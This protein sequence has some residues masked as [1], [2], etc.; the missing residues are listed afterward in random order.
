MGD[1]D[2]G[3]QFGTGIGEDEVARLEIQGR[4]LAPATRMI[5]AEAGI[6]PGMRVL[7]LGCGAGDVTFV[8]ADLVGP[9]GSVVGVDRSTEALAQARLRAERRGLAQ[10]Q[11][12][13][14]DINDPAPGGP[15][16]AIVERLV[17]WAVP[18]PAALLRRQATVL[19]TGGLVV[20]IET[21]PLLVCFLPGTADPVRAGCESRIGEAGA[22][23]RRPARNALVA[24]PPK[25]G[26]GSQRN[27]P[28]VP[29]VCRGSLADLWPVASGAA[30]HAPG[31]PPRQS[32][33][34]TPGQR[35]QRA[36]LDSL[37][38]LNSAVHRQ[39]SRFVN[40]RPGRTRRSA[41]LHR[42]RRWPIPANGFGTYSPYASAE[43]VPDRTR[44][45]QDHNRGH[46]L[47]DGVDGRRLG[48]SR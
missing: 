46:L 39:G 17:L 22:R 14:G 16:D 45:I 8:A 42:R 43:S 10:V 1:S 13:E 21:D 2:S 31:G 11:F 5:F 29:A 36:A 9:D 19:R 37:E 38:W 26:S 24:H 25:L 18:D 40:D 23:R 28:P 3:F 12:A 44:E 4:A 35:A 6:R 30:R 7:D 33:A 47:S 20:L 41:D 15:F 32:P 27:A 34:L 48:W